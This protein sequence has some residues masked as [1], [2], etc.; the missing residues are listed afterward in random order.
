MGCAVPYAPRFPAVTRGI[1]AP[2]PHALFS[3]WP[4]WPACAAPEALATCLLDLLQHASSS[5]DITR[6]SACANWH[7]HPA[8]WLD[9]LSSL[10]SM[11]SR[12]G[13][14]PTPFCWGVLPL[15]VGLLR[16]GVAAFA[17]LL[18]FSHLPS[19]SESTR[20]AAGQRRPKLYASF[21][22]EAARPGVPRTL[23]CNNLTGRPS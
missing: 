3:T 13:C 7:A 22:A 4:F 2:P 14:C 19:A 20:A 5:F 10:L 18:H 8:A 17:K 6:P 11:P 9:A 15:Y 16:F 21:P 12:H 1:S 23:A